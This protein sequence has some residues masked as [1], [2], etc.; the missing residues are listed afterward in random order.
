MKADSIIV[1][2]EFRCRMPPLS[3][4]ERSL[5]EK[6]IKVEGCRD[7][8]VTWKNYLLDGH[9]RYEI[10][11]KLGIEFKIVE[12][13]LPD[14]EAALDWIDGNQLGRRNLTP[15][16]FELALGRRYERM[17]RQGA[18]SDLTSGQIDQKSQASA[19]KDLGRQ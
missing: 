10:C 9:T 19:A 12:V 1:D 2:E 11:K 7:P 17:K 14:R 5:L 8:F 3:E 4:E 18:R 15:Q 13:E 16:Q 6:S